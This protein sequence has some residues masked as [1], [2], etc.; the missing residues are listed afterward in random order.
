MNTN[1]AIKELRLELEF[2]VRPW[3]NAIYIMLTFG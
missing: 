2:S 1:Q 3:E